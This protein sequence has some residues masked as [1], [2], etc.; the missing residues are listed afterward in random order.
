MAEEKE[1]KFELNQLNDRHEFEVFKKENFTGKHINNIKFNNIHF[2][3]CDF[4]GAVISI[5]EFNEKCLFNNCTFNG[6]TFLNCK[7]NDTSIRECLFSNVEFTDVNIG[8]DCIMQDN[9]WSD[10]CKINNFIFRGEKIED[11]SQI[12][13]VV[14]DKDETVT[15][16]VEEKIPEPIEDV[17][18]EELP[19][20]QNPQV[21]AKIYNILFPEIL[22]LYPQIQREDDGG[23]SAIIDQIEFAIAE[24]SEYNGWRAMF[25]IRDTDDCLYSNIIEVPTTEEINFETLKNV[26]ESSVKDYA[27]TIAQRTSAQ[28]I[29]S[30][31]KKFVQIVFKDN[32][33]ITESLTSDTILVDVYDDPS[34]SNSFLSVGYDIINKQTCI[35][36]GKPFLT[37]NK[38]E[39]NEMRDKIKQYGFVINNDIVNMNDQELFEYAKVHPYTC[40]IYEHS[41]L[42]QRVNA[43]TF[44]KGQIVIIK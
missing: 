20:R 21:D 19:S 15:E 25:F 44:G 14:E 43:R 23:Y 39:G 3:E 38:A 31:L 24:D 5:C 33:V 16:D 1:M 17:K 36:V 6:T 37:D 28:I 22:K 27:A 2:L 40:F 34:D 42:V 4:T 8:S 41:E 9:N 13:S 35:I 7:F 12:I 30:S 10:N 32:N 26:F 29:K 11:I 18:K